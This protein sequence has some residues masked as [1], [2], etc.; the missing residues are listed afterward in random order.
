MTVSELSA[1]VEE[2]LEV[3]IEGASVALGYETA[4]CSELTVVHV[5]DRCAAGLVNT[6]TC[7]ECECEI[8]Q[9]LDLDI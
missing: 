4:V 3:H 9:E 2:L 6:H 1:P 7:I 8:L 5:L